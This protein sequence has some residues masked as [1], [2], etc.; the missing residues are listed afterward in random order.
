ML[1]S[2]GVRNPQH[3]KIYPNYFSKD[4]FELN[5]YGSMYLLKTLFSPYFRKLDKNLI[6]DLILIK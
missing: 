5:I 4:N 1:P 2:V 6:L 3:R